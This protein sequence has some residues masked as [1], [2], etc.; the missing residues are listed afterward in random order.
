MRGESLK[1]RG[2]GIS[3]E[4]VP[5][6]SVMEQLAV[7]PIKHQIVV[8]PI[9]AELQASLV[10]LCLIPLQRVDGCS[11]QCHGPLT[12][13]T[14]SSRHDDLRASIVDGN[15]LTDLHHSSIE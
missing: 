9:L 8:V 5:N 12:A 3:I 6:T 1:T 10:L 11:R 4:Y 13:R 15:R 7:A 14:L 2:L